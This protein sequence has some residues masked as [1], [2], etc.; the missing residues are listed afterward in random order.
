MLDAPVGPHFLSAKSTAIAG[1]WEPLLGMSWTRFVTCVLTC[2]NQQKMCESACEMRKA[3][4]EAARELRGCGKPAI[5]CENMLARFAK[6][7]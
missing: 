2:V 6:L 3:R 1:W 4:E 5:S 7:V